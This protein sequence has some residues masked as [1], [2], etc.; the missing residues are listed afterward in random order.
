MKKL[1]F[2]AFLV[3]V[4]VNAGAQVQLLSSL[5]SVSTN[6]VAFPCLKTWQSE[7]LS[8]YQKDG[9][10]EPKFSLW[11]EIETEPLRTLFPQYRFFT[12][13]W[14]EIPGP[15]AGAKQV[16]MAFGLYVILA[17]GTQTNNISSF[18]GHGNYE[19]FGRFL[20]ENKVRIRT[21]KD[22]RTV[23]TAFCDFHQK[24]W[25][26]QGIERKTAN[27]WHLGVIR[28]DKFL[29]YYE[30]IV[31]GDGGVQNAKLHADAVK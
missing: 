18:F 2:A 4:C 6:D 10:I 28:I 24:R 9:L 30:V 15:S 25:E 23:W 14:D 5:K 11:S 26:N 27:I 19:E 20:N 12:V 1:V 17:V 22:A 16:G 8:R 7:T 29:Y 13:S 21:E 31:D 3:A